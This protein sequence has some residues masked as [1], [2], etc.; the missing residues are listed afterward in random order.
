MRREPSQARETCASLI[1]T[2]N[3]SFADG[4]L[5]EMISPSSAPELMLVHW[6]EGKATVSKRIEHAGRVYIPAKLGPG[7]TRAM[8]FPGPPVD[9]GKTSDLFARI[10][11]VVDNHV[12]L[13]AR[14]LQLIAGW[15]LTTWFADVLPV[16]PSMLI[17]SPFS[18]EA[19]HLLRILRA[20]SRRGIQLGE[21]STAGFCALPIDLQP[22]LLLDLFGLPRSLA[23]LVR[24][25]NVRGSYVAR[26]GDLLD[27]HCAKAVFSYRNH[28]DNAVAQNMVRIAVAPGEGTSCLGDDSPVCIAHELQPPL[29]QYRLQNYHA[30]ARSNFAASSLPAGVREVARALGAAI[31]DDPDLQTRVVNLLGA[32][33]EDTRALIIT[34]R[35][36]RL[37]MRC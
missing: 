37:S 1:Q 33:D 9:Y 19:A 6:K 35:S 16:A 8:G 24:V 21:V 36:L 17:S 14:D 22:T 4:S 11:E 32:Q 31:V 3:E 30:V 20:V 26:A 29:L 7:L 34:C 18:A 15:A 12:N 5:I 28:V 23:N 27:L 13:T 25:S 2:P 10:I